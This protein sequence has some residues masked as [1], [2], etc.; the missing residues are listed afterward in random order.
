MKR[1]GGRVVEAK[2]QCEPR[3][4]MVEG[5]GTLQD[6]PSGWSAGFME[7]GGEQRRLWTWGDDLG[8]GR[9][10]LDKVTVY[11]SVIYFL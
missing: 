4:R 6:V 11:L 5:H 7:K 1:K 9:Q 2:G 10:F 3:Q 8:A